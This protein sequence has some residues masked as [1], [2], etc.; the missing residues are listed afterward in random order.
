[1]KK[2]LRAFAVIVALAVVV[3]VG[4]VY[5]RPALA[6]QII[7]RLESQR[8]GLHEVTLPTTAF[9]FRALVGGSGPPVVLLHGF[10]SEKEFWIRV[11][12]GL[13]ERF[14]VVVPDLPG[15]GETKANGD[16]LYFDAKVQAKRLKQLVNSLGIAP[17]Y[18]AGHSMGGTIAS[19][20]A[21]LFPNDLRALWLLNPGGVEGAGPSELQEAL[22]KGKNPLI[23]HDKDNFEALAKFTM[24][25]PPF[26]PGPIRN[27]LAERAVARAEQNRSIF[28]DLVMR[29]VSVTDALRGFTAPVLITWGSEDRV[30]HRSG[31]AVLNA[32]LPHAVVKL[33][34][35]LGHA[36]P[37]EAPDE[38]VGLFLEF[39][40][41]LQK[42]TP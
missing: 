23:L 12:G 19:A 11:A 20:Y 32:V 42:G 41:A 25:R 5:L 24:A 22:A 13:T 7:V 33:Q 3:P 17:L 28:N 37:L 21:S 6:L 40:D 1:M 26:V 2:A 27:L 36:P 34:D 10:G 15:F 14:S 39:V 30:V 18:L 29:P 38:T 8:A 16:P 35:G 9:Q 31:A 4:L